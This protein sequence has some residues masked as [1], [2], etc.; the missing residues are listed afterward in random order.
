MMA[1]SEMLPLTGG[2]SGPNQEICAL[3]LL[4]AWTSGK[5]LTQAPGVHG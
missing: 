2:S 1:H 5:G 4:S 3:H